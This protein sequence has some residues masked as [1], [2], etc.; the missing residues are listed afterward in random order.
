MQYYVICF[1]NILESYLNEVFN[2]TVDASSTRRSD[3]FLSQCFIISFHI[4]SFSN[5]LYLNESTTKV[6]LTWQQ[7][8]SSARCVPAKELALTSF[9]LLE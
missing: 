1:Q 9:I 8:M 2:Y 5:C 4:V 7:K 3:H 6:L